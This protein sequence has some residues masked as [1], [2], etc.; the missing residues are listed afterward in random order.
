MKEK[1]INEIFGVERENGSKMFAQLEEMNE[2]QGLYIMC[3]HMVNVVEKKYDFFSWNN[4]IVWL[5]EHKDEIIEDFKNTY[6][7]KKSDLSFQII[8][9]KVCGSVLAEYY[10]KAIKEMCKENNFK[11]FKNVTSTLATESDFEEFKKKSLD[12][13]CSY[14]RRSL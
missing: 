2:I 11:L 4:D 8:T 14:I 12:L 5:Y 6:N 13:Q 10:F 3:K 7:T 9:G 1:M